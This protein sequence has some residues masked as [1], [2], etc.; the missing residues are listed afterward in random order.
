MAVM[1]TGGAGFIGSHLVRKLL[2]R[3]EKVLVYDSFAAAEP[4]SLKGMVDK[5]DLVRGNIMDLSTMVM[6]AKK[7]EVER[8]VH[9]A[10]FVSSKLSVEQPVMTAQ[11][12]I[13]GTL[14]VLET[15]K[16]LEMKRVILLSSQRVYGQGKYEPIDEEHPK[17]PKYPYGSTKLA[18]ELL[19][20]NY[21]YLYGVDFI[22]TR[23]TQIYGPG[24]PDGGRENILKSMI[25]SAVDGVSCHIPSGGEHPWEFV[26]IKDVV[27]ALIL[28]L[29]VDSSSLQQRAFN[30]SSGKVYT[31]AQ[32]ADLIRGLVPGSEITIGPGLL[33]LRPGI[34]DDIRGVL[35]ISRAREELGFTPRYDMIDGLKDYME[36]YKSLKVC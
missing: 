26:Y 7:H 23:H 2:E 9:T 10:G 13:M 14:N 31:W 5:I 18:A 12:N 17:D 29:Y 35:D 30:I 15:A 21:H 27:D 4:S 16:L 3:G 19:G 20:L 33:E 36:W 1:V 11:V 25:H 24:R 8:I 34:P 32:V 22:A 6:A 28:A